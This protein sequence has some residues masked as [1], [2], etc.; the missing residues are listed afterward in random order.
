[1]P[2]LAAFVKLLGR[3]FEWQLCIPYMRWRN[4]A[5]HLFENVPFNNKTHYIPSEWLP[6][7][8]TSVHSTKYKAYRIRMLS[9]CEFCFKM[10][11]INRSILYLKSGKLDRKMY[12]EDILSK[13]S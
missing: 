10:L 12:L 13:M 8:V 2:R 9:V 5:W 7:F 3:L 4:F 6:L 11:S 1:V